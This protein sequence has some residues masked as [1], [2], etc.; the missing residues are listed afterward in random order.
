[1]ASHIEQGSH[2]FEPGLVD[3]RSDDGGY[4]GTSYTGIVS[5]WDDA[6]SGDGES[7]QWTCHSDDEPD[8]AEVS[9]P[10]SQFATLLDKARAYDRLMANA[11]SCGTPCL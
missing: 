3:Y 10:L 6:V 5:S 1:M 8:E 11:G 9:L 7:M 4:N 2:P